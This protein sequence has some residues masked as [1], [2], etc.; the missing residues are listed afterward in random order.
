[1]P[2]TES[3]ICVVLGNLLD[4]AIEAASMVK[5]EKRW[6]E[7]IIGQ[8][9]QMLFLKIRNNYLRELIIK[10]GEYQTTKQN[11]E[12]HGYGIKSIRYTIQKY[13]G[14]VNIKTENNWFEMKIIIPL[15]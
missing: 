10:K 1:M 13:G 2:I 4:N 14:A 9:N 5:D 7:I 6:I 3:E 12:A 8:Q 15:S 11:K